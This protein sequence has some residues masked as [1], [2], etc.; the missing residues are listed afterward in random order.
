MKMLMRNI[1][2][3]ILLLP[4]S[5]ST[6]KNQE[7]ECENS[8]SSATVDELALLRL[9]KERFASNEE[10]NADGDERKDFSE[11]GF[12]K[13]LL[14]LNGKLQKK[15][16]SLA[17]AAGTK[18]LQNFQKFFTELNLQT[19]EP[20]SYKKISTEFLQLLRQPAFQEDIK[21]FQ[22]LVQ[23][24]VDTKA[25]VQILQRQLESD[26]ERLRKQGFDA[27]PAKFIMPDL[28]QFQN[29]VHELVQGGTVGKIRETTHRTGEAKSMSLVARTGAKRGLFFHPFL[30]MFF[31]LFFGLPGAM[32]ASVF[33]SLLSMHMIPHLFR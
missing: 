16:L 1:I 28:I 29:E 8:Y 21:K 9:L 6:C 31:F 7:Q 13:S 18:V 3:F 20:E 32:V 10:Q 33:L 30:S 11:S 23:Q 17:T 19:T 27:E 24:D 15:D 12:D 26:V 5:A 14:D 4:S 22:E 2:A 25:A